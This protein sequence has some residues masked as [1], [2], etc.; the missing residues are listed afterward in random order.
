ML[1]TG[2][3]PG[4]PATAFVRSTGLAIICLNEKNQRC[5]IGFLRDEKHQFGLAVKC[6][7][8]EGGK[9]DFV[10]YREVVSY[11]YLPSENVRVEIKTKGAPEAG[12]QIY[13]NGVDFD[14]LT[15]KD[16]NDFRWLVDLKKLHDNSALNS[17][18]QQPYPL[19]RVHLLSGIFHT[20]QLDE[21]LEFEKVKRD[22]SGVEAL[23]VNFGRVA[24]TLGARIYGDEITLTINIG[25]TK[26][27]HVLPRIAG[28]PY[29]IELNNMDP[30]TQEIYS[31][32]PDYYKYIA[33]PCGEQV[34]LRP[35]KKVDPAGTEGYAI[36]LE[37]FCHPVVFPMESLDQ[38]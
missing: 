24:K 37:D 17:T 3:F 7:V 23:P 35:I 10:D 25:D 13:Q 6:P 4:T 1:I 28:L 27:K 33:S 32:M 21:D 31:D 20:H 12:C 38:L 2:T 29:I 15:A 14:R 16:T 26:I 34:E 5:E 18:A 30:D 22:A 19:T 9:N 11:N 36:S 8:Y